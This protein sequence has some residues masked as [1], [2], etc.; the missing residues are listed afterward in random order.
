VSEPEEP[1]PELTLELHDWA[2]PRGAGS[3]VVSK[4][5]A[6]C[7]LGVVTSADEM[8]S[9]PGHQATNHPLPVVA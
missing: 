4:V 3:V 7:P 5:S 6:I 1:A 8:P 2:P 9:F